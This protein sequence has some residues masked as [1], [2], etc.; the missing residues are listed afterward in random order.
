MSPTSV[1]AAAQANLAWGI[2]GDRNSPQLQNP[3][4]V[5]Y[6]DLVA[7]ALQDNG[8]DPTTATIQQIYAAIEVANGFA[9]TITLPPN[10]PNPYV[11]T[12]CPG[13][14]ATTPTPGQP[15]TYPAG[16]CP[17][18][19]TAPAST[20]STSL[21]PRDAFD[22][23]SVSD[24][25]SQF[26]DD[27]Y[28]SF[29]YDVGGLAGV[30][31]GPTLI[32][33]TT[34]IEEAGLL[35]GDVNA[36]ID[37]ALTGI[38]GSIV[39]GVDDVLAAVIASVQ[40]AVTAL[41][42]A[43]KASWAWLSRLAG[44]ILSLLTT[45]IDGVLRGVVAAIQKIEQEIQDIKSG[46]VK[47][48]LDVLQRVRQIILDI[49]KNFIVPFLVILQDLRKLLAILALFHVKF[50]QKLDAKLA[51]LE[52]RITQPLLFI[53]GYVNAV[54][55]WIN[56]IMAATY[57]IQ[58]SVFLNSLLAY[59]G[60]ALNLQLNAM[61]QPIDGKLLAAG[62]AAAM[63]TKPAQTAADLQQFLSSGTGDFQAPIANA[64]TVMQQY[65]NGKFS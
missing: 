64:T 41:G 20:N 4:Q 24:Y 58:K 28:C 38:W 5:A 44:M 19:T 65:A 11:Q 63:T 47:P 37:N 3:N 56:L 31:G 29:Y 53:L 45:V 27:P 40:T 21:Q 16:T 14:T 55:N 18:S 59:V 22:L 17:T 1:S 60:E 23:G 61:N 49:W 15:V 30:I 42:N 52:R 7:Q 8:I 32:Q 43:V 46:I 36:M 54:S 10:P 35:A 39:V 9:T 34:I 2:W 13:G 57:L 25:C 51:D 12:T 26:P 50:A 33:N 48:I 62:Q 6:L